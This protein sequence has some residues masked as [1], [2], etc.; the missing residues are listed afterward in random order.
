[1]ARSIGTQAENMAM[2]LTIESDPLHKLSLLINSS[3]GVVGMLG[4]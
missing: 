2:S 1:M 4:L 3:L